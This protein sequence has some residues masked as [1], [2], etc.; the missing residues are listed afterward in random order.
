[1]YKVADNIDDLIHEVL[2]KLL[3]LPFT[4]KPSKGNNSEIFGVMLKLTN[5][6]ARISITE[7]KGK[8]FSSLGEFF[9]YLSGDN[10]LDFVEYYIKQ[11]R[12]SSDDNESIHGGYGSRLFNMR[13]EY[14]QIEKIVELLKHNPYTRKAVIQLFDVSDLQQKRKDVPC[15]CT[16]QFA[17]RDKKLQMYVSMRSN[18]AFW[19]LSHDIFCFTML[20]EVIA[21]TLEV[22]L[23]EYNHSVASMHLYENHIDKA[24][25]YL[26]EG[27]QVT[28][29]Q[30]PPMPH[31]S[32]WDEIQK[33]KQ[34]EEKLRLNHNV[35]I[36]SYNL[37]NY[38]SDIAYIFKAYSLFKMKRSSELKELIKEV[39]N[40]VYINY[41]NEK[42][43]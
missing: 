12:E 17:I 8:A 5:P 9:W 19:G 16:L 42:L 15:T 14:N 4:N 30:M 7:T 23:G 40:P 29:N 20:Q 41:I 2:E 18:D 21:R 28:N 26:N 13:E 32:P 22:E 35:D 31:G 10:K 34:I 11:Y 36:S 25:E 27:F 6:R 3:V 37:D 24:N 38:W 39:N 43:Y 1:M 33:V